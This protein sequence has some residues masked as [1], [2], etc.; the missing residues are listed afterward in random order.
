MTIIAVLCFFI[1]LQPFCDNMESTNIIFVKVYVF[2]MISSFMI[3]YFSLMVFTDDC[4]IYASCS[5]ITM[6]I[7]I[8]P[9]LPSLI[10]I[11]NLV[12]HIY[13]SYFWNCCAT[14]MNN[15]NT[16]LLQKENIV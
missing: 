15:E 5:W 7:F 13:I 11:Y 2:F 10:S 6:V 4:M 1:L 8:F 12:Y 3:A 14:K 9:I 16:T